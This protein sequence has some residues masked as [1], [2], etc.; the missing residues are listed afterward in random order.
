M[1]NSHKRVLKIS[2]SS[3]I[4]SRRM[5]LSRVVWFPEKIDAA[6]KELLT[7]IE[8]QRQVDLVRV[9]NGLKARLGDEIDV[10]ELAVKLGQLLESF[11][12]LCGRKD[13][14]LLH[15]EHRFHQRIRRAE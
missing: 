2:P 11:A 15:L 5:T 10:T 9:R 14:A 6:D 8:R 7:L 3:I 4:N 13:I 12:Q 1:L